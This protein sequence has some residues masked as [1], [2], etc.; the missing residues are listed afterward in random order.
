MAREDAKIRRW[1]LVG[2]VLYGAAAGVVLLAPVSYSGIVNAIDSWL[3]T[4]LGLT[5]F[6]SGWVE[7]TANILLFVPLGFLLT[8][9]ARPH[10]LG[11]VIGL[12]V[13]AAVELVQIVIPSR[14]ASLRDVLSN[15]C[16]AAVGAGLA[17]LLVLRRVS[18]PVRG[19]S[20]RS[21]RRAD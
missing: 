21:A 20:A 7:F 12:L 4:D 3:R 9:I 2:L 6:G 14:E 10:W 16:G 1:A 18:H 5:W 13:S 15:T 8:L 17:W 19:E 11:V